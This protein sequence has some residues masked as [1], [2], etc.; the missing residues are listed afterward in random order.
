MKRI[1][2][3]NAKEDMLMVVTDDVHSKEFM[4]EEFEE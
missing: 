3:I 1:Y 2:N 4:E